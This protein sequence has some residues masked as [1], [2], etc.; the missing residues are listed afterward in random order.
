ME[1]NNIL[2]EQNNI[3]KEQNIFLVEKQIMLSE[4]IIE[5]RK[6]LFSRMALISHR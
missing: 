3:L 4:H 5:G 6:F 2:W 1:Q